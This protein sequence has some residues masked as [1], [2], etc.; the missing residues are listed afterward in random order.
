MATARDEITKDMFEPADL[1]ADKKEKITRESLSYWQDVYR[2]LK[3][4]K[5]AVAG[6]FVILAI[7]A[8]AYIGP[9]FS[10]AET[11]D[12][13]EL[14]RSN[15]PPK[16]SWLSDV[17]WLPFTGVNT[18]GID[19]YEA[20]NVE[21]NY[22]FGA[23]KLGRDL[24]IRVWEGTKVSLFI[25][26]VAGVGD[27]IIGVIYGGISGYFGGRV[28][29]VMERIIEIL[30]GIPQL[31]LVIL[32]IVVLEPG[33]TAIIFAIMF[34][35]WISQARIV[36]GQ[37]LQLKTQEFTLAARALG[38]KH[39]RII[40]KHIVPNT[41]GMIIITMMFSIPSAIFA[42]AFLSFIGLGVPAPQASLGALINEGYK[43]IQFHPY[44]ALFPG[45]LISLLLLAFNIFGDGLRDAMDP[46]MRK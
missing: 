36:R 41:V 9:Y 10:P 27:I 20:R 1:E 30:I 40:R 42:E 15:L 24:W 43:Q 8:M 35:G 7:V 31:V 33:L 13:Q 2:R 3:K 32:L 14:I 11:I 12:D 4:N 45:V 29:D 46:K 34:T 44:Q 18:D 16:V 39:S 17:S 26:L 23:D 37:T 38:A 25:G 19:M 6:L 21:E 5:G 22:W 28:D